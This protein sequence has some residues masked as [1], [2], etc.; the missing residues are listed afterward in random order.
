MHP[1]SGGF[2][3]ASWSWKCPC[4]SVQLAHEGTHTRTWKNISLCEIIF[5]QPVHP[6]IHNLPSPSYVI[7]SSTWHG[8][9]CCILSVLCCVSTSHHRSE[10]PV[11]TAVLLSFGSYSEASQ[12]WKTVE[13][14]A[15]FKEIGYITWNDQWETNRD[16]IKL[17]KA[18]NSP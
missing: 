18:M 4:H 9:C 8:L 1:E 3:R 17:C 5:F 11:K 14:L 16:K 6:T 2:V 12:P 10:G 15:S 13:A 7:Y